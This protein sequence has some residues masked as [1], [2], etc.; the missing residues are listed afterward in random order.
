MAEAPRN[1]MQIAIE[2]IRY[3]MVQGFNFDTYRL[4]LRPCLWLSDSVRKR[5]NL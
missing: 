2:S 3:S 1:W 4:R 5:S